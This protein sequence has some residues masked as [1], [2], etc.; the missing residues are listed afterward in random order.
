MEYDENKHDREMSKTSYIA[1]IAL[2]LLA[3]GAITY[4]ALS[5]MKTKVKDD[6]KNSSENKSYTSDDSS[7]ND[8]ST[9][10]PEFY[11]EA[12]SS[13]VAKTES[14]IPYE[15]QQETEE[16]QT[17]SF[18]MPVDGNII[19]GYS[20]SELQYSATYGDLRLHTGID[21]QT[22]TG[23]DVKS[24]ADGIVVSIEESPTLGRVVT[25]EHYGDITVKYCGLE[26]LTV[27]ESDVVKCGDVI[28]TAGTVP[29]EAN[30]Q[31]HIHIEIY[32]DGKIVSPAQ[33]I[34]T[35]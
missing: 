18:I 29:S 2:C 26:S 10:D 17:K 11:I 22:K 6:N 23:A 34:S 3:I 31:P 19:K 24:A 1:I 33:I 27:K 21:I 14:D 5:G 7:Y 15:E 28:G 30:D 20:D 13:S 32:Q 9:M 12:P 8:S 4:F 25:I 16:K 35:N